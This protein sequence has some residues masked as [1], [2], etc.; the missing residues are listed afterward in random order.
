MFNTTAL[1]YTLN[2][3]PLLSTGA[4]TLSEGDHL[5]I[6]GPSGCGKSTLLYLLSGLLRP[7]SGDVEFRGKSYATC[8]DK[9]LDQ[10]R[11]RHF[12][13]VFQ[14][15]HLIRH[16]T[17]VQNIALTLGIHD[18][19]RIDKVLSDLGLIEKKCQIA[20]DLSVGE[21]QRVALARAVANNPQVIF[22]DEPTSALDDIN[23]EKAIALLL[24]QAKSTGASL[25][26]ATH[27]ARIKGCFKN[28]LEMG[29]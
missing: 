25:I 24:D 4:I 15:L 26:V 28:I 23:T 21:A 19:K 7:T 6:L 3:K 18:T 2:E 13:F 5:L 9:D 10:L 22:A 12:G 20:K 11:A 1:S 27:D 29:K 14:K 8:S 16:L 17:V